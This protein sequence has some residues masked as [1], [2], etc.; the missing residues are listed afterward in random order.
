MAVRGGEG[1]DVDG[2]GEFF[3][4]AD[5]TGAF[6]RSCDAD[7]GCEKSWECG[8]VE[9]RARHGEVAEVERERKAR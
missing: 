1:G 8:A 5:A 4:R 3:Q 2:R 7:G 6:G 9:R